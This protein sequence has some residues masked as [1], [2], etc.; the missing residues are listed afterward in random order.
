MTAATCGTDGSCDGA[1][2]CR[3]Y[4]SGHG[5][6]RR[7][8]CR[9]RLHRTSTCNASGQCIKPAALPCFPYHCNANRCFTACTTTRI[10]CIAPNICGMN[11]MISSCGLKP[12]GASCSAGSECVQQLLR[13]GRLLQRRLQH[14]L[15]RL[16]PGGQRRQLHQRRQRAG[17]ARHVRRQAQ[18]DLRHDRPV[19]GRAVRAVGVGHAVHSRHLHDRDTF[20]RMPPSTCNGTG[21][22]VTPAAV[23]CAPGRC[24]AG[25]CVNTCTT[26][27]HTTAPRRRSVART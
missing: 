23:R 24:T 4:A 19:R 7:N 3:R 5:L 21:M 15:P 26:A 17:P 1:G 9:R 12:N 11:G 10:E 14:R 2:A 8:L 20:T 22:C 25:A 18:I 13:P 16:Q 27:T 6:R